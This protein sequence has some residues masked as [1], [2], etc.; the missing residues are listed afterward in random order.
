MTEPVPSGD[1]VT[2]ANLATVTEAHLIQGALRAAGLDAHVPDAH[3]SQTHSLMTVALGGVRV[4]VPAPQ[5]DAA[6]Q[7]LEAR[8]QGALQLDS[9]ADEAN[10]N[11]TKPALTTPVFSPD[12]ALLLSLVLTPVFA[13]AVHIANAGILQRRQGQWLQWLSLVVLGAASI[14]F[15]LL[16]HRLNPGPFL[17]FRASP[18]L[19]ALGLCW[20]FFLGGQAQSKALIETYGPGYPRR[21][22]TVPSVIA[23]AVCLL[24]GWALNHY[25]D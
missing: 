7:I 12:R 5:I 3:I 22:L 25:L 4:V 15:V 1:Y 17:V 24:T 8:D 2:V 20:Y 13:I 23:A 21:S 14:T 19:M 6:R 16:A 9:D 18:P 10:A 11:P